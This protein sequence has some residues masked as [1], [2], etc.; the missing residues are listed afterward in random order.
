MSKLSTPRRVRSK[1][2]RNSSRKSSGRS[3]DD[4]RSSSGRSER[5]GPRRDDDRPSSGR[6]RSSSSSRGPSKSRREGD[7][8][9]RSSGREGLRSRSKRDDDKP[10]GREYNRGSSR[11]SSRSSRDDDRPK[12]RESERG[13]SKPTDDRKKFSRYDDRQSSGKK[14]SRE[15]SR[16]DDDRKGPKKPREDR[17]EVSKRKKAEFVEPPNPFGKIRR[18]RK[19]SANY[20]EFNRSSSSHS[21]GPRTSARDEYEDPITRRG[22]AKTRERFGRPDFDS[23]PQH[24]TKCFKCG[25]ECTVPFTPTKDTPIYCDECYSARRKATKERKIKYSRSGARRMGAAGSGRRR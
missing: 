9:S 11:T 4:D 19:R 12:S 7:R 16:P 18:D 20:T 25:V 8:P 24:K 17:R 10:R 13:R 15:S 2:E 6:T 23:K 1:S 3:S 22:R 14:Y 5:R 21:D